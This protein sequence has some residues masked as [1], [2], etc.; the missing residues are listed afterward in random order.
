LVVAG[1]ESPALRELLP[2]AFSRVQTFGLQP[3][4]DWQAR[5]VRPEGDGMRFHLLAPGGQ[6]AGEFV[7][8][9][10]GEHNVRNALAALAAAQAAGVPPEA[11]RE[12][13]A[14]FRGVKRRLE[15]RGVIGGI[16]V[17]DDFAHHPTA[18]RATLE[19]L[20]APGK[21]RLVAVFE[22][23]SYTSRTRWFQ[24]DFA[25][26][27]TL[28][29]D[30]WVAAAHLPG[31]VPEAQRLSEAELVAA[32]SARGGSARFVPQ[33]EAIVEGLA[34]G[35]HAGD[36]VVV[37]SNGG[38]GGLHEKLLAALVRRRGAA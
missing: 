15:T 2:R 12:A 26:A 36:R 31:K 3:G 23:R 34:A 19:A 17:Y 27:F 13:L 18:V 25:A 33:V 32:I 7:L 21:G 5:D 37:L 8:G 22:P 11:C 29:D 35:L 38:F 14:A 4:A 6:D 24:E 20:R 9:L 16:T 28:A 30:V 1:V 10:P